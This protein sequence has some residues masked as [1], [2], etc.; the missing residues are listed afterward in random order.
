MKSSVRRYGR[1]RGFPV[2]R[3]SEK[4][5]AARDKGGDGRHTRG[6]RPHLQDG[7]GPP[8]CS[9]QR[10]TP[11]QVGA[12]GPHPRSGRQKTEFCWR[13]VDVFIHSRT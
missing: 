2:H 12:S 7:R 1:K 6:T 13:P 4:A 5:V 8:A 10:Q 3:G 11:G 9:W